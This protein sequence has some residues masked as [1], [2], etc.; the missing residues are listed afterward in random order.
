MGFPNT[1]RFMKQKEERQGDMAYRKLHYRMLG[2]A[3]CPPL[4]AVLAGAV[5]NQLDVPSASQDENNDRNSLDWTEW[6]LVIG[7][8]LAQAA[9]RGERAPLPLGCMVAENDKRIKAAT[10]NI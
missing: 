8:S 9:T 6:G 2:N 3:V 1:Y 4:V 10:D 7:I 5:L